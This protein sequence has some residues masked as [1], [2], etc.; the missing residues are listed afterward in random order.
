MTEVDTSGVG[1]AGPLTERG[2]RTRDGLLVA[3][4]EV[5][6]DRGFAATRMSDIATAAEVSHGTV[7]TYFDTKEAVLLAVISEI[8]ADLHDS[9]HAGSRSDPRE[10]IRDA[11]ERYLAAYRNAAR[12]LSAVEE[13]AVGDE[14][15]RAILTDLRDTHVRRVSSA[16]RRLQAEGIADPDLAPQTSAAALCAMVEGF[17][18]HWYGRGESHDHSVATTTLTDLWTRA[19]GMPATATMVP[20]APRSDPDPPGAARGSAEPATES[21]AGAPP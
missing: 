21:D 15:F 19:L 13:A 8:I 12:L 11:N 1:T 3:A 7:Y 4:R 6:E 9:L 16:I 17:A 18:R 10:R 20:T 5:F 2:R 14:R